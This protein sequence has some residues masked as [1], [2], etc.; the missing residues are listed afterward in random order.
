MNRNFKI[1]TIMKKLLSQSAALIVGLLVASSS[2]SQAQNNIQAWPDTAICAGAQLTLNVGP[3]P[4]IVPNSTQMVTPIG[5]DQWS[6]IINLPFPF[7][8]YGSVYNQ[9]IIGSNGEIGFNTANA[10]LYNTWPISAAMPSAIPAD[11]RNTIMGPW[12]DNY[13]PSTGSIRIGTFGTAPN[14]VFVAEWDDV[15]MY[16]CTQTCIGNQI[17]LFETTN[18]IEIHIA[19]KNLC[20]T[21]NGGYAIEGLNNATGTVA[22]IVP[23]RNYPTQWTAFQDAYRFTPGA[24][25]N[26]YTMAPITFAPIIFVASTNINISWFLNGN[27]VGNGP[28]INVSP[29]QTSNYI[30][31][32]SYTSCGNY[33][34]RDT[35]TVTVTPPFTL[36]LNPIVNVACFGGSTGSVT[37]NPSANAA[38]PLQYIWST[39]PPQLTQ[40]ASNLAANTYTV[41]VMDA[42]GCLVTDTITITQPPDLVVTPDPPTNV[43]CHG[44]ASGAASVTVNGGTPPYTYAWSNGASANPNTNLSG[45]TYTVTVTDANGCSKTASITVTEPTQLVL[46]PTAAQTICIGTS[47]NLCPNESGG[48]PGYTYLWSD[49]SMTQCIN[50]SPTIST[51]YTVTVTDA[52]GC[53]VSSLPIFITVNPPLTVTAVVDNA[54]ICVGSQVSLSAVGV[55]G[56]DGNY[57]YTWIPGIGSTAGPLTASPMVTTSY[58]VIVTDGCGTPA[59]ADTVTVTVNPLPI[60]LFNGTNLSGCVNLTS[61]FTDLSN[62]SSG[63]IA[64]WAWDFGDGS[65]GSN[66]QNPCHT[67]LTPSSPNKYNVTLT[68]TSSAGCSQS[69]TINNY[70]DAH[71]QTAAYFSISPKFTTIAAPNINFDA[72]GGDTSWT[73][74]WTYGDGFSDSG[75]NVMH[76]YTQVNKYQVCLYT[77]NMY[78]CSDT[79]C[80]SVDIRSD[81]A[82]Y[83][84]NVFTPNGDNVNELFTPMGKS[85]QDYDLTIY[86]RWGNIVFRSKDIRFSWDGKLSNGEKAPMGIYVYNIDLRDLDG[87]K[88]NFIGNVALI[89]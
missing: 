86:D 80:D 50:V 77:S 55:S 52:N 48:T 4:P 2:I 27:P 62:I 65:G 25:P 39:V 74:N 32:V 1:Q 7:T 45:N 46:S 49:G 13:P 18:V 68:V 60:S 87:L 85:F 22:H 63:S 35:V 30:A 43:L 72:I 37:A 40:T 70:V 89:R 54:S 66:V 5:D 8:F 51:F 88:H 59:A 78:N 20:A 67:Y 21:W 9:C 6:P 33:S 11:L 3:V 58:T 76:A 17:H 73:Y 71:P 64:Q 28:S 36:T 44:Q 34:F 12:Q 41:T 82:F 31:Q 15:A 24:T 47:V 83:V 10:T 79:L 56:G 61:C 75:P 84:P 42:G 16:S 69:F 38:Q 19:A 23:G 53:S 26:T 29:T 14:R 57:S 81:F